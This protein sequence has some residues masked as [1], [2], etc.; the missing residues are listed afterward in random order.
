MNLDAQGRSKEE[1]VGV[2]L[3]FV[4]LHNAESSVS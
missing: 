4:G 1:L 2:R 3:L